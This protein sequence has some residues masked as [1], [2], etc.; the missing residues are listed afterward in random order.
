MKQME[1]GSAKVAGVHFVAIVTALREEALQSTVLPFRS[2]FTQ[3][4]DA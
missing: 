1:V 3:T 4:V 2:R